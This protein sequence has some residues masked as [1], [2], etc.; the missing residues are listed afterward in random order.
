MRIKIIFLLGLILICLMSCGDISLPD[1]SGRVVYNVRIHPTP[2]N[3]SLR[4]SNTNAPVNT[5]VT[6]YANPD[7]GYILQGLSLQNESALSNP[8]PVNVSTPLYSI[9]ITSNMA[10][11]A[12]FVRKDP[13]KY[14]VSID[15]NLTG[16]IIYPGRYETISGIVPAPSMSE[17]SG[18]KIKL[19]ILPDP[20]LDIA[21]GS[22]KVKG[23]TSGTEV[24]VSSEMP[25]VFALPAED[26]IV[27]ARFEELQPQDLKERA[28]KYLEVGEYDTAAE[29]YEAA[30]ARDKSDP[31]LIFYSTF[32]LLGDLLIDYDFRAMLGYGSLYFSP[33][34]G[35]IN[36]WVCDN[37]YWTGTNKWYKEY[38]ATVYTPKDANLPQFYNRFSGYIKPFGDSPIAQEPGPGH[39]DPAKTRV[40]TRE[41]F[42]NYIF[43]ALISSYRSGFNPFV[44]KVNRYAFGKK[45]EEALARARTFPA[46]AKV[47]LNPRLLDR[48]SLDDIYAPDG[49]GEYFI[50]KPELEYIFGT[51]LSVRAIFDYLSAYDL[52]IELRNW[53]IDYVYWN[54]GLNEILRQMFDLQG[55]P[56]HK[57]LWKDP[58]TV[59]KMSPLKN[60][61]L[62]IR[63]ARGIT[64]AKE[65]ITQALTMTN[66]AMD[67]WYSSTGNTS[68]FKSSAQS[69]RRWAKQAWAQAKDAMEGRN[70][71]IFYFTSWFPRTMAGSSWPNA[72][73]GEF[74]PDLYDGEIIGGDDGIEVK[75]N[76]IYGVN[77]SKFF[78]L[79]AFTLTNFFTTDLGG[80]APNLYKI[81]WYEDWQ[82][83]YKPVY[84]GNYFP[85]TALFTDGNTVDN[86]TVNGTTY[87]APFRKYSF[88]V[89]TA[90]LK[91]LFPKGFGAVGDTN[92][93]K[94]LVYKVFPTIPLWPW[95]VTY[96][97]GNNP[98]SKLYDVYHKTTVD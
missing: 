16:G 69:E 13:V 89:N 64:K 80:T 37:V 52:T 73:S 86:L 9:E 17:S 85:V 65:S 56:N 14:T 33:V 92:G 44:E 51:L 2:K 36:D 24:S 88:E 41:K 15:P 50:G 95:A 71:G 48:F 61:F 34:P 28:W 1:V 53:L 6:I 91:E 4:L 57:N 55:H 10:I 21:R 22:L 32:G 23:V 77:V 46:T 84:T 90:Y 5:Y 45:F 94:E 83:S 93:G 7:P 39:L 59:T 67:Y 96:F 79:G 12:N 40:D 26:V 3:G 60:N 76:R 97:S 81:E 58:G 8:S 47:K 66:Y 98:A 68:H 38:A 87:R 30:Y 35:T 62:R 27:E 74:H 18:T 78:T 31:E 43:W 29:L 75:K 19:T 20:G 72:S 42:S 54:Q 49:N 11:T 82:N 25:Y 70:N 63:D